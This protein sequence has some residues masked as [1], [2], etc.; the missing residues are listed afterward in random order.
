[1]CLW[2]GFRFPSAWKHRTWWKGTKMHWWARKARKVLQCVLEFS[3]RT[4]LI[5]AKHIELA[6]QAVI[7]RWKCIAAKQNWSQ[8][9][10][11]VQNDYPHCHY[12]ILVRTDGTRV[13]RTRIAT[14]ARWTH[15]PSA[16]VQYFHR[17]AMSNNAKLPV[18]S[19]KGEKSIK[20]YFYSQINNC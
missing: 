17:T 8:I 9:M 12:W 5:S 14:V 4:V 18:P 6:R 19:T 3:W 16:R 2:C 1:M 15:L 10:L 11:L 7:K 13:Q 20:N